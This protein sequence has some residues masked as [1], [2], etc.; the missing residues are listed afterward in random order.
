[1][2][3]D[4]TKVANV[5]LYMLHKKVEHLND[6]KLSIMLFLMEYNHLK[7]CDKKIFNEEFIKNSRNPEPVLLGELFDVIA[8]NEDLDEEDERLYF[9]QELL[10][11]LDIELVERKKFVELKFIKMEEEFDE[12]IFDADEMKTIHKIVSEFKDVSPR[13]IANACF[14]IDDL[15]KIPNGEVII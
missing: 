10:D 9:I 6:K 1:M 5:I 8:N 15:R 4:M 7:F 14:Q 2:N 13:N 3:V 12:S 11:Y